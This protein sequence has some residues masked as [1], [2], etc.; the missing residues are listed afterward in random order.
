MQAIR[1]IV[2]RDI[3]KNYE[4]PKEFGDRFEMILLPTVELKQSMDVN[5]S[6]LSNEEKWQK[7]G[8]WEPSAKT[9]NMCCSNVLSNLDKEHGI[10]DYE[11]WQK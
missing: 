1:D 10:E 5:F 6:T 9:M 2:T 3:F 8:C 11:A 4:I 7:Y